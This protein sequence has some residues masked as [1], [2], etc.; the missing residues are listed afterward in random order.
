M[1]HL[2]PP[3]TRQRT[4]RAVHT[5]HTRSAK[6]YHANQKATQAD[7]RKLR[8]CARA[9]KTHLAIDEVK[10]AEAQL[11]ILLGLLQQTGGGHAE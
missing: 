4:Q 3:T 9:D 6:E 10:A 5:K 2:A 1:L 8:E 7:A 11:L